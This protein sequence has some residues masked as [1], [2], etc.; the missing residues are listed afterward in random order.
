TNKIYAGIGSHSYLVEIDVTTGTKREILPEKYRGLPGFV[1]DMGIVRGLKGGDRLFANLPDLHKTL[2]YNLDKKEYDEEIPKIILT[3]A[4]VK[5][6]FDQTV[7]YTD[8]NNLI[9][10]EI[11]KIGSKSKKIVGTERAMTMTWGKDKNLYL[12]S[13]DGKLLKYNPL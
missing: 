1:Y 8:S 5:S 13:F 4:V 6:P 2:V 12:L 11:L 10:Y 3:K 9:A 7:Y